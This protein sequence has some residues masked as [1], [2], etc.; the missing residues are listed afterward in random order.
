MPSDQTEADSM[1]SAI[2]GLAVCDSIYVSNANANDCTFNRNG[3]LVVTN[4]CR[5]TRYKATDDSQGSR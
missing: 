2:G 5:I 1:I 4:T 3:I